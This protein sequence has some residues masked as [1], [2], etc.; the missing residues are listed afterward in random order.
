M[1]RKLH[2][3]LPSESHQH[4]SRVPLGT[5]FQKFCGREGTFVGT[6]IAFNPVQ[7]LYEISY[8]NDDVEE[9]TWVD[10][11]KLL[12]VTGDTVTAP[13][14]V[15]PLC[16]EA[17]TSMTQAA[18]LQLQQNLLAKGGHNSS[19]TVE[20]TFVESTTATAA[21]QGLKSV[22][23]RPSSASA[24]DSTVCGGTLI[25]AHNARRTAM[26]VGL[27][28]PLMHVPPTR[29]SP[30]IQVP[31]AAMLDIALQFASS[32]S[33]SNAHGKGMSDTTED[34]ACSENSSD[35]DQEFVPSKETEQL[36]SSSSSDD[37]DPAVVLLNDK[38]KRKRL[39]QVTT[40]LPNRLSIDSRH[41]GSSILR[42]HPKTRRSMPPPTS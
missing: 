17:T 29:K 2:L 1:Q 41:S 11:N 3:R 28:V 35:S 31:S 26:P 14:A 9:L 25:T 40:L 19:S 36:L 27:A 42:P 30:R 15:P 7:D 5:T 8:N 32:E 6:L 23:V 24:S 21:A 10:L 37:D 20:Y 16:Q 39:Q 38:A 18:A 12:R 4:V 22:Q 34:S 33:E 13:R